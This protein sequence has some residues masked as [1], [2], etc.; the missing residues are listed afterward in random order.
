MSDGVQKC[1][2]ERLQHTLKLMTGNRIVSVLTGIFITMI[3]QSSGATTVMVVTFVNAGLLTLV[4]AI[5]VIFGANIGTTITA[6]IVALFA[7]NNVNMDAFAIPIFGIGFFLTFIKRWHKEGLGQAIMGFGLLFMGLGRLS[8]LFAIDPSHIQFLEKLN[9]GSFMAIGC[10]V[11]IGVIITVILHSSSASTAI[12]ITMATNRV[13]GWNLSAA[14]ILGSNIGSTVDSVMAAIGTKVNARRAASIH[15]MFNVFGTLL[16]LLFFTPLL[17][18]VDFLIP[19]MVEDNMKYH[20][21]MLH[22]VFNLSVTAVCIPFIRQI[23]MLTERLI[24]PTVTEQNE[25]YHLDFAEFMGKGNASASIIRAEKEIA[26]MT[27][28]VVDLFDLIQLEL[29]NRDKKS[30]VVHAEKA[31]KIESYVDQMHEQIIK[32]LLK[33]EQLPIT[34][35]QLHN[36][37]LMLQ[38]VDE[39]ENMTDDCYS[40]SNLLKKSVDKKMVFLQEDLDRLI[41]YVEL[42]RQFVTFI[43]VNINKHLDESKAQFARELEE[44]IDLFRK[45]LKKIARKRLESG[46][47]VKSEL[48]YIDLVRHIEKIG[49][50]AFSISEALSL[51]K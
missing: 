19:G 10:G 8:S 32:Y 27:D 44:Q 25:T 20:V 21:A 33:C 39:L 49:D 36:V 35:T 46:A 42:A 9:D 45:N 37:S 17:R 51:T 40:V 12:I 24:K 18:F 41:P 22:T 47:D 43:H 15:V 4:Q 1:A 31:E 3:I 30:I 38:I 26:A 13:L 34:S 5:G 29:D 6:W 7:F 50:C 23:A 28:K 48:L 14:M 2:G 11:L 16:A